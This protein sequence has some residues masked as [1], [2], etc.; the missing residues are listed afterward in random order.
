MVNTFGD[1]FAPDLLAIFV[2]NFLLPS[3]LAHNGAETTADRKCET[4]YCSVSSGTSV[5]Y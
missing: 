5:V 2:E 1:H 3:K 4:L